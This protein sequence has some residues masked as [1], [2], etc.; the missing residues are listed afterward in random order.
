MQTIWCCWQWEFW[1]SAPAHS[2][3]SRH[4]Q[5]WATC[6]YGILEI[7][8]FSCH[9]AVVEDIFLSGGL[10]FILNIAKIPF[11]VVPI[12]VISRFAHFHTRQSICIWPMFQRANLSLQTGLGSSHRGAAGELLSLK[13]V[14]LLSL[15]MVSALQSGTALS[16][17]PKVLR[18]N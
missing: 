4:T 1:K 8:R 15:Q 17:G 12:L 13:S 18:A 7:P 9:V 14:L 11:T 10:V 5:D 6:F 3:S 16:A 2:H